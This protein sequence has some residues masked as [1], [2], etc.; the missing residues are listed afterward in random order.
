MRFART[1]KLLL[2]AALVLTCAALAK[3]SSHYHFAPGWLPVA[4]AGQLDNTRAT[5]LQLGAQPLGEFLAANPGRL[6]VVLISTPG[7]PVCALVRERELGPLL[8]QQPALAERVGTFEIMMR[9]AAPFTPAIEQLVTRD[10]G[11]LSDINSPA[12][13][14]RAMDLSFAPVVLF[15]G[16]GRELSEPLIGYSADFYGAYLD[17]RIAESLDLLATSAGALPD[18]VPVNTE[19][20]Q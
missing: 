7:C 20:S 17:Q 13:L 19:K 1:A 2:T 8:R 6:A 15:I 10:F 11:V 14:S 12:E 9:D 4:N 18:Q 16:G 3:Q 5:G